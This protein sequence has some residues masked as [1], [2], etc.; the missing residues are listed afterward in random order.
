MSANLAGNSSA[1]TNGGSQ[2]QNIRFVIDARLYAW[3]NEV[4]KFFLGSN[5]LKTTGLSDLK[6][7]RLFK[8]V[9][10][11]LFLFVIMK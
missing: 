3:Y 5:D 7:F 4:L 8:R 2:M 11:I 1:A 10:F 6:A 9:R